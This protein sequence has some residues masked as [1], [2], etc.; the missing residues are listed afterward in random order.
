M[1]G[2][3]GGGTMVRWG[4]AV[5]VA[6]AMVVVPLVCWSQGHVFSANT[7]LI[8]M[9]DFESGD[10]SRWS[11]AT[12]YTG[13]ITVEL[14][15]G[16][17]MELVWV[18]AGTFMMGSPVDERGRGTDEDLHQVTLTEGCFLG[19]YEVT[20]A[21]WEAVMGT[22]PANSY[23]VGPDY[24]VYYVSWN[25]VC[26]GS[27]GSDCLPDSFVGLVNAHLGETR[28]RMPTEAEWERVARADTQTRFSHGDVLDCD[29]FCGTCS[30][31]D[32]HMWWCGNDSDQSEPVGS[33]LPNGFGLYDMHG[34]VWE[35]VADWYEEHLGFNAET[36][37]TGP[38]TGSY[39]VLRG[40][41]WYNDAHYCRSAAR[42]SFFPGTRS[43][44]V[45]F[46]LA[47]SP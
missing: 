23:G 43:Y 40:G 27:T 45:G 29:D 3:C 32:Q 2:A 35:W 33:K 13:T 30:T 46:R 31:H 1:S 8:F 42:Y 37:P 47:R 9:D 5:S 19:K 17:E 14:P 38:A 26:G 18:P 28:Y 25:D 44:G 39:R 20:Q 36:D 41:G 11:S 22:N 12:G 6:V 34:N 24:P 4:F 16:V 21:Q 7:D 10:V 15:G